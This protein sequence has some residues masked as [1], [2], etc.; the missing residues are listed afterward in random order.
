MGAARGSPASSS[1]LDLAG[2]AGRLQA[3]CTVRSLHLEPS[4]ASAQ[5]CRIRPC[6]THREKGEAPCPAWGRCSPGR[7]W[8]S[9]PHP[10]LTGGL[11]LPWPS[12]HIPVLS[13][14]NAALCILIYQRESVRIKE[15]LG[16]EKTFKIVNQLSVGSPVLMPQHLCSPKG[17]L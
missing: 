1:C 12:S 4:R 2:F 3:G 16:S 6:P 14:A 5:C 10:E 8:D 17:F 7:W 11:V 15:Q 13:M 9:K